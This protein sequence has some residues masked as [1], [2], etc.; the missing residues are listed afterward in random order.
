MEQADRA[1]RCTYGSGTCNQSVGTFDV[2]SGVDVYRINLNPDDV[3]LAKGIDAQTA[4]LRIPPDKQSHPSEAEI[5]SRNEFG[6]R[7]HAEI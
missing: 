4:W 7:C 2:V 1:E 5:C 3:Q 6:N